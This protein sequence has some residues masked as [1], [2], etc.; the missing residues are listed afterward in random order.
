MTDRTLVIDYGYDIHK[1][2]IDDKTW[3]SA[4]GGKEISVEG[5]GFHCEG[6]ILEDVWI[7]NRPSPGDLYVGAEDEHLIFEG[8]MSSIN[9]EETPEHVAVIYESGGDSTL[10]SYTERLDLMTVSGLFWLTQS[11]S[12]G[13]ERTSIFESGTFSD[14]HGFWQAFDENSEYGGLDDDLLILDSIAQIRSTS[15]KLAHEI[16]AELDARRS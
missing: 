2:V 7:F 9:V 6:V 12:E 14:G 16:E 4:L 1:I 11:R 10:S 13:T 5:Q 8:L 3:N 15:S